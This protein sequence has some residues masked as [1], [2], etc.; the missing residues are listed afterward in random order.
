MQYVNDFHDANSFWLRLD[1]PGL[2]SFRNHVAKPGLDLMDRKDYQSHIV[3]NHCKQTVEEGLYTLTY[4]F[5]R[6]LVTIWD[7]HH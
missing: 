4:L 7:E 2:A 5:G 6:A 1:V 3:L